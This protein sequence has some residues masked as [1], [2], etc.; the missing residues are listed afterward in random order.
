MHVDMYVEM[1]RGED[2]KW[3]WRLKATNGNILATSEAYSTRAKCR[4]TAESVATGN[5]CP[6]VREVKA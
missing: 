2:K 4:S 5:T 6:E 3:R 1:F